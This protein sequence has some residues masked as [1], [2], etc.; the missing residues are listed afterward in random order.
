LLAP[1]LVEDQHPDHAVV[2]ALARDAARLARYG[3]LEALR[4]IEPW[5]VEVLFYYAI[6]PGAEPR[7]RLPAAIEIGEFVEDWTRLMESHASQMKTRRY[8]ELQLARARTLGL[9]IGGSYAQ[10]LWSNDALLIDRP[11]SAR[12]ARLY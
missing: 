10:A 5:S 9:Q 4:D 8:V 12:G 1:S 2:G 7:D 11:T 3:G 6:T